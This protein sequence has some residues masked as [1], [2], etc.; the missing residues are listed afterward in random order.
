VPDKLDETLHSFDNFHLLGRTGT[1]RDMANTITFLPSPGHQLGHRRHLERRR[2]C[3][4][5]T[6][7]TIPGHA[8]APAQSP[9]ARATRD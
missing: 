4:G 9:G 5:R 3:H 7:L 1:A 8:R 2:R 6:Q